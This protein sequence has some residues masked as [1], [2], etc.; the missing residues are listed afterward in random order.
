[1]DAD[2]LREEADRLRDSRAFAAAAEAYGRYLSLRPA[3][4]G[5]KVQRG[6]CLKESG[7]VEA[8]L[9][10][11]REA[12]AEDPSDPDIHLQIG[13]ALK[14]LGRRAEAAEAYGRSL[15]AD[16]AGAEAAAEYAAMAAAR[17]AGPP[18][19][20]LVSVAA[21]SRLAAAVLAA[22][23]QAEGLLWQPE[24]GRLLRLPR[25]LALRV[26]AAGAAP[27]AGEWPAARLVEGGALLLAAPLPAAA[28]E[29]LARLAATP[30][31]R[32]AVAGEGWTRRALAVARALADASALPLPEGEALPALP[33]PDAASLLAALPGI[34]PRPRA[35]PPPRFGHAVPLGTAEDGSGWPE[36]AIGL[37][38]PRRG[39]FGEADPAGRWLLP[40]TALLRL[41][42][43]GRAPVRLLAAV[44]AKAPCNLALAC[45]AAETGLALEAD[46]GAVLS[47]ALPAGEAPLDLRLSVA[48]AGAG[49]AARLRALGVAPEGD[50]AAR[51]SL[52]EALLFR[53][54]G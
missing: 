53:R 34:A 2:T 43:P 38:A 46:E 15:L 42:R 45:G 39:A 1:M 19:A 33:A 50:T 6:H 49:P 32:V 54:L 35:L 48:A 20:L 9:A 10:L 37:L 40:G 44:D 24:G 31:A 22:A 26:A 5:I 3:D 14:L 47:L 4:R 17:P 11:Y 29:A 18:P 23:P 51:L 25:P 7:E 41:E 13:H 30:G 8:A 28:A 12:E 36:G 16:P 21:P 52:H 27:P